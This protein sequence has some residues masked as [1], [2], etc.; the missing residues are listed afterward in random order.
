MGYACPVC[1]EPQQDA[2]H[3]AN[4]LAFQ[5]MTHGGAHESWLDE[6]VPDW[7]ENGPAELAP[8]AAALAAETDYEVVFEDTA[9]D[10]RGEDELYDPDLQ[11]SS[12]T[13]GHAHERGGRDDARGHGSGGA[14]GRGRAGVDTDDLSPETRDVIDTARDLT[15]RMYTGE[16]AEEPGDA[17]ESTAADAGADEGDA[18]STDTEHTG[19]E[20]RE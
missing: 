10:E 4:H 11:G 7:A 18:D 20:P 8:R 1:D 17:G 19:S 6:H 9:G 16:N 2:E 5:A 14:S 12:G 15:R 3:L 13:H